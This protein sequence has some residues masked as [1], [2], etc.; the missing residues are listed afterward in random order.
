MSLQ[1]VRIQEFVF[2]IRLLLELAS[3]REFE[4]GSERRAAAY[5]NVSEDL[6]LDS[7]SKL[8]S[9]VEFQK[10]SILSRIQL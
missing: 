5:L 2:F 6:S 3:G 1:E 8:P 4:E 7:L 10:K 9:P